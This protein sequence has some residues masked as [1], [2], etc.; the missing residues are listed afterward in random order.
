MLLDVYCRYV[1]PYTDRS[2]GYFRFCSSMCV[3]FG[4]IVW[5]NW[6][7]RSCFVIIQDSVYVR[8]YSLIRIIRM[9]L[10][11]VFFSPLVRTLYAL[12]VRCVRSLVR[13]AIWALLFLARIQNC[14]NCKYIA[15]RLDLHI[16]EWLKGFKCSKYFGKHTIPPDRHTFQPY[17]LS[18][19]RYLSLTHTQSHAGEE[20]IIELY[21]YYKYSH[22]Y[23]CLANGWRAQ[24][25]IKHTAQIT[26]TTIQNV[27]A[28]L[29]AEY[30]RHDLVWTASAK[31][32]T[33]K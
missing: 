32:Q 7:L 14:T 10:W 20:T 5:C 16:W 3:P 8:C 4:F 17:S 22:Y 12:G 27:A 6:L 25:K 2:L 31:L 18:L 11:N 15:T 24:K 23:W 28:Q 13:A 19:S 26:A 29:F 1:R 30:D 9:K 33:M 21:T